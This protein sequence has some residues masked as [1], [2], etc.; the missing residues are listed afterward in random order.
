M[1]FHGTITREFFLAG[2]YCLWIFSTMR[3]NTNEILPVAMEP[4][5]ATKRHSFTVLFEILI[6]PVLKLNFA[7]VTFSSH[8]PCWFPVHFAS[9]K[10]RNFTLCCSHQSGMKPGS[11]HNIWTVIPPPNRFLVTDL[12]REP[13]KRKV[14]RS[15]SPQASPRT[16]S[17]VATDSDGT[18]FENLLGFKKKK[19]F[20]R[21]SS[22][23]F[24]SNGIGHNVVA[25]KSIQTN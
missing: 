1:G 12:L 21:D 14:L 17:G 3:F 25:I 7:S 4:I 5:R 19:L 8:F 24:Y 15:G 22:I 23:F 18:F 6:R 16:A 9:G 10:R 2:W 11:S 13:V 20:L